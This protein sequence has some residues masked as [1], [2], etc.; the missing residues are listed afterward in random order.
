MI[1]GVLRQAVCAV[2]FIGGLFSCAGG[3]PVHEVPEKSPPETLRFGVFT[4]LG[5][6]YPER[7]AGYDLVVIDAQYYG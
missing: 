6:E 5:P 4:G 3:S 7:L 2:F 1:R